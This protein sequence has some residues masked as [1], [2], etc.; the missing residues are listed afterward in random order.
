L[1]KPSIILVTGANGFIGSAICSAL[2]AEW[3]VRASVRECKS[4]GSELNVEVVE[5][6]VGPR[7][8]WEASLEGVSVVVHTAAR[9]HVM[10]ELSQQPFEAFNAVN[11]EGTITLALQAEKAGV[12][13]FVFL[14]SIGVNGPVSQGEALT[15]ESDVDP[16]TDY[17]RSK[18]LAENALREIAAR[19]AMEVV[20][21]RPPLVYGPNAPGNFATLMSWLVSGIPLPLGAITKNK[22]SFVYV[23]NLVDLIV[24]CVVSASAANQTFLVSD[25]ESLSTAALLRRM[26]EALGRPA[27]LVPVPVPLLQM[28]ASLLGKRDMAQR[29][30]GSLEVHIGKTKELLGWTPPI[31]VDEGLRRT[32]E[33]WLTTEGLRDAS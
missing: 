9:V 8:N 4:F 1:E 33:H 13:R 21:I 11:T 14:S 12:K 20:I 23:E 18:L 16:H 22:R 3:T 26:G 31:S 6:E 7:E 10:R 24:R 19:S 30:C 25:G 32:A 17:A 2:Q 27:R 5:H 29:L 28:G 15:E